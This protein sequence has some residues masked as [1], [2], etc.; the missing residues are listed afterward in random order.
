M[1]ISIKQCARH[2]RLIISAYGSLSLE[3]SKYSETRYK[4]K[5]NLTDQKKNNRLKMSDMKM[6]DQNTGHDFAGHANAGQKCEDKDLWIQ[7]N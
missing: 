1:N 3:A 6:T 5:L 7:G 2:T 4:L